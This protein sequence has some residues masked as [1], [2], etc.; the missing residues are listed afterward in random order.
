MV[1]GTIRNLRK[2]ATYMIIFGAFY[3][4]KDVLKLEMQ[5]SL[6]FLGPGYWSKG[7]E[8][9]S[10]SHNHFQSILV[11]KLLSE[12][13]RFSRQVWPLYSGMYKTALARFQLSLTSRKNYG[14][15]RKY[16]IGYAKYLTENFV[17]A[18]YGDLKKVQKQRNFDHFYWN[19]VDENYC[20]SPK[21]AK[22]I[23]V[24]IQF[25]A[26]LG[27]KMISWYFCL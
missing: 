20:V 10:G 16:Q 14:L 13:R 5:R 24:Q 4:Y 6:T 25:W 8:T 7:D 2:L 19:Q 3:L 18:L 11:R 22:P 15:L 9:K 1:L 23:S 12:I 26:C 27:L 21:N 17:R